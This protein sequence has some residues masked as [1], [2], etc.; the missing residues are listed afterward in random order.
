LAEYGGC[1]IE[2]L[3]RVHIG[4]IQ[5]L[6]AKEPKEPWKPRNLLPWK[7]RN[8]FTLTAGVQGPQQEHRHLRPCMDARSLPTSPWKQYFRMTTVLSSPLLE[9]SKTH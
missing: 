6:E 5:G 9:S 3:G 2:P 7:P 1:I 4:V 8:L